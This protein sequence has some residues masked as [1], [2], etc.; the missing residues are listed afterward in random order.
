[1]PP[2]GMSP[3]QTQQWA[4]QTQNK[5]RHQGIN[6]AT[7]GFTQATKPTGGSQAYNPQQNSG[8]FQAYNPQQVHYFKA[9]PIQQP[10]QGSPDGASPYRP[11]PGEYRP[12]PTGGPGNPP[13]ATPTPRP[14]PRQ[15]RIDAPE[16]ERFKRR[17]DRYAETTQGEERL[18]DGGSYTLREYLKAFGGSRGDLQW[19]ANK[20][21]KAGRRPP[22]PAQ[23]GQPSAQPAAPQSKDWAKEQ[24]LTELWEKYRNLSQAEQD[25]LRYDPE[26]QKVL[27]MLTEWRTTGKVPEGAIPGS[28][29]GGTPYEYGPGGTPGFGG[30]PYNPGAAQ[31]VGPYNPGTPYNP[32]QPSVGG[33]PDPYGPGGF[34]NDMRYPWGDMPVG[35]DAPTRTMFWPYGPSNGQDP[36][37]Q[38]G[39][40]Y[41]QQMLA[42][43]QPKQQLLQWGQ[44]QSQM[45]WG[46]NY[47]NTP[48]SR[49]APWSQQVS[50]PFGNS[51]RDMWNNMG[52]FIQSVNNQAMQKPVGT[53]LGQGN[54]G[55]GY[56]KQNYDPSQMMQNAQQLLGSGWQNPFMPYSRPG[57][58]YPGASPTHPMTGMPW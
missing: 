25:A 13:A 12:A 45:P 55:P 6:P 4:T 5:L 23:P 11:S 42:W 29:F 26:H 3:E 57:H 58:A 40:M 48:D 10:S 52:A 8:G 34:G 33:W 9:Q 44:Q 56:G 49:P 36:V 2:P 18:I 19:L 51:Q 54:P 43:A 24:Q 53:Y 31:P 16:D 46:P 50:G 39:Q 28:Q 47:G 20:W 17:L 14:K 7:Y 27:T 1:M 38:L 41:Q 37:S 15:D 32:G 30:T 35:A 21:Q 22:Q